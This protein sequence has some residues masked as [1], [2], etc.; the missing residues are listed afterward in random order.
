MWRSNERF[1]RAARSVCARGSASS[2]SMKGKCVF[3]NG[4]AIEKFLRKV[5]EGQVFNVY[6]CLRAPKIW[7]TYE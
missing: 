3:L 4:E 1:R 6:I 2:V 7:L 5:P